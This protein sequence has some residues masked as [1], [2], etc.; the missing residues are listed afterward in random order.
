MRLL[1]LIL[2][3]C[4]SLFIAKIN[5]LLLD[6]HTEALMLSPRPRSRVRAGGQCID[7]LHGDHDDGCG[8]PWTQNAAPNRYSRKQSVSIVTHKRV[9]GNCYLI[10]SS[11]YY[12]SASGQTRRKY[13]LEIPV[14]QRLR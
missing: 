5:L 3:S 7:G 6:A 8:S 14:F 10:D 12:M 2:S 4:D 11:H 1:C 9:M 13:A